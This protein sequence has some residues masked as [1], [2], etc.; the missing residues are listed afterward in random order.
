[1]GPIDRFMLKVEKT[2]TCWLW[3]G[4]KVDGYGK[5]MINGYSERA[6]RFIYEYTFGAIPNNMIVRHKCRNK[7]VNPDHL[8][9]GTKEQN[10]KDKIR[11]KTAAKKL[12]S[13]QVQYIKSNIHKPGVELAKQFD[14][15]PTTIHEIRNKK[16]W[17]HI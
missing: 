8:E 16:T 5:F 3:K 4:C 13:E 15:S 12:T 1:M 14:V 6:H 7:C 17:L 2:D 10:N 11:D 9:L